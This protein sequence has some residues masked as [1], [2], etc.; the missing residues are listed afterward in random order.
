MSF[1]SIDALQRT[2][3]DT[4]FHYANDRK[5]AAGR[6]LGTLVE[7][8]TYYTLCAW[9][10]SDNI[11]IERKIPEYANH[12]ILHNVE[13]ALHPIIKKHNVE[14]SPLSLPITPVKISRHLSFLSNQELKSTQI[15]SRSFVKR[16]AA[17]L[18]EREF[19]PVIANIDTLKETQCKLIVCELYTDPFAI[20]ECKR[21]GVEE[22]MKKGP[23]TIEKAKQGAYVARSVSALQK[24]RMRNGQF[25]GV[26]EQL[27]GKFQTGP[28]HE[29]LQ[30]IIDTPATNE[31]PGFILTVGIVSNHGNW[32]TS[33]NHNKELRVLA[34]S[35]DWLLFLTDNGL[36][37]FIDKL[38]LNP[39]EELEPARNAFLESYS[40]KPG[41]NQFT[42]VRI[43][44]KADGA[45]Q[46]YFAAHKSE[47][48][49]WFNIIAPPDS[50]LDTLRTDLRKLANRD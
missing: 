4:V 16:N 19:G 49:T 25:K 29:I 13:F 46:S 17:V 2:L 31:F 40:G 38:L 7:I 42:K 41:A 24:V 47:I 45:L 11:V 6:A 43:G 28:Y 33:D 30:E 39:S 12:K 3:A 10:L 44:A 36:S 20:F 26:I 5:K 32:F 48:E 50:T 27:D 23:Q 35:Y 34:Q 15:L 8:V 14:L 18:I 22:G 9:N 1:E 37:Q 21:V